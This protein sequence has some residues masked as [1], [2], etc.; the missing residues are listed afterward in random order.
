MTATIFFC[1]IS[2]FIKRTSII[3]L[4]SVRFTFEG[5]EKIKGLNRKYFPPKMTSAEEFKEFAKVMI[6]Y[7]TDYLE[8]I[9]D[10]KV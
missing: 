1:I 4:S 6:D 7:V 3:I 10:R 9:R 2:F 8:N 5:R